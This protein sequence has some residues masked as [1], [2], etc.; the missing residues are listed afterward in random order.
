MASNF[1]HWFGDEVQGSKNVEKLFFV[2]VTRINLS[3]ML[4][5]SI[6][7]QTWT[8]AL[9]RM[10]AGYPNTDVP[11]LVHMPLI[12]CLFH[13]SIF[14]KTKAEDI[15]GRGWGLGARKSEDRFFILP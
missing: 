8:S 12:I 9:F 5:V 2:D 13:V 4:I 3:F 14:F 7:K 6:L 11:P 15:R 10:H 1:K